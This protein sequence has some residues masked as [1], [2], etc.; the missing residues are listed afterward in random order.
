MKLPRITLVSLLTDSV[1]LKH[2]RVA[3]FHHAVVAAENAFQLAKERNICPDL[4]TKAALLHDI[5]HTDWEKQGEWDFESYDYFDIHPI[6]GA[7]RAHELLT[8]KG[9]HLGKAREIALAILF[10]SGSSPINTN[11]ELTPLQKL[12]MEADDLDEQESGRHHLTEIPLKEAID[13]MEELDENI[14]IHLNRCD[15]R[16]WNCD[17]R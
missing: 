7:E 15:E 14:D 5:G 13:R 9:E 6:K 12:V 8:L 3:G 11:L 16:C 2:M 4:S 1:T 17:K 10:H